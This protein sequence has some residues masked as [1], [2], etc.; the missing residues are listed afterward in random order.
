MRLIGGAI[1]L[2]LF[3][4]QLRNEIS[5][6]AVTGAVVLV[7]GALYLLVRWRERSGH[8]QQ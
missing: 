2:I 1:C 7:Y 3:V 4:E 5:G 6:Y 8:H